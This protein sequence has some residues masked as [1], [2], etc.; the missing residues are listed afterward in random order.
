MTD[1][2]RPALLSTLRA[3][4]KTAGPAG[5][6]RLD[7]LVRE[8]SYNS[9]L[10]AEL[11]QLLP[12]IVDDLNTTDEWHASQSLVGQL[13]L[14]NIKLGERILAR[15]EAGAM[16][17]EAALWAAFCAVFLGATLK[18][19]V[20]RALENAKAANPTQWFALMRDTQEVR[21]VEQSLLGLATLT[22][23]KPTEALDLIW[24]YKRWASQ[25]G[26]HWNVTLSNFLR[27]LPDDVEQQVTAKIARSLGPSFA[28]DRS[29]E[30]AS[31]GADVTPS[32]SQSLYSLPKIIE[33]MEK[34]V[35]NLDASRSRAME[36]A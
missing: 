31:E 24:G 36:Y 26:V 16:L 27:A 21:T 33:A 35:A 5:E 11:L 22:D 18:A 32:G 23:L 25:S 6:S 4:S 15:V 9:A 29:S 3:A 17:D 1:I 8:A 30:V 34:V 10:R 13:E 7:L 28:L 20:L 12:E 19:P 2:D 14:R